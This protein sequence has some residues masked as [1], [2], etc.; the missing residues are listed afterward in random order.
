MLHDKPSG[1]I[2]SDG[3]GNV[4]FVVDGVPLGLD[5]IAFPLASHEGWE[6]E[7]QIVDALA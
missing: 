4:F 3:D 1:R 2:S 7:S 6:F 5:E